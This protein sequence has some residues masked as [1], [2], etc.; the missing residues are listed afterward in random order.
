MY[1][2]ER[3]CTRACVCV[4]WC[5]C[6]RTTHHQTQQI[7]TNKKKPHKNYLYYKCHL[8]RCCRPFPPYPFHHPQLNGVAVRSAHH[9]SVDGAPL[10]P[11]NR[12]SA[13]SLTH[14]TPYVSACA[15]HREPMRQRD[16]FVAR[17]NTHIW[18]PRR[19]E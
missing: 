8:G 9:H 19:N 4:C 16:S 12:R 15:S 2:Y 11:N 6:R 7:R 13:G 3:A 14:K 17:A 5:L 18:S 1:T 10:C